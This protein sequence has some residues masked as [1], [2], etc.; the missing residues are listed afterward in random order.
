MKN[1]RRRKNFVAFFVEKISLP[2]IIKKISREKVFAMWLREIKQRGQF[3]ALYAILV[4]VLFGFVGAGIDLGWYYFNVSRLQNAADAAALAGAR[5]IIDSDEKFKTYDNK[6]VRLVANILDDEPYKLETAGD[7][8]AAAYVLKNISSNTDTAP[9]KN[10]Y[11]YTLIDDWGIGGSSE[12]KMT[13]SLYPGG[14]GNFYYVVHLAENVKHLFLP[15]WFDDMRAP[16]VAVAILTK[17]ETVTVI[18]DTN[19][20]KFGN[21]DTTDSINIISPHAMKDGEVSSPLSPDK[22]TPTYAKN[23]KELKGWSTKSNH[24]EGDIIEIFKD[25]AQLTKTELTKLFGTGNTVTLYAVWENV[26]PHNNRTLWEQMHYLIAKNVYDPDWDVS[27]KKYG[28]S[29]LNHNSF[30]T[31]DKTYLSSYHYYTEYINL[32]AK[33]ANGTNLS[34]VN[35]Y[36]IDFRRNDWLSVN[37]KWYYSDRNSRTHSLFN[38]NTTYAV[39]SG[40]HDDPMYLRIE[41]EPDVD[42]YSSSY[43][44][45]PVRQ[46]IIN[47]NVDNT[48]DNLRP[49][50][51]YYDGPDKIKSE[52]AP[53]QPVILNLNANFK[54]V[55][56]MPDVPVVINGNG[57]TFEGFIVASEF[58]CLDTSQGSQVK[59]SSNG[60]KITNAS[61]NKIRVNTSN[62]DVYSVSATGKNALDTYNK[63]ATKSSNGFNLSSE[64][65]FRSFTAET[66]VKFNYVFYDSNLTMD[67]SPFYLN[68]GDLIP[69]YKL[70]DG[71]Q[72]R[73]TKWDEVNLYDNPA[74]VSGRK[75]IQKKITGNANIR[76]VRLTNGEPSPL[77]D[78]AGNPVYFCEDYVNLTGTYTVFT[79]DRVADGTRDPKEFLLTKTDELNVP[80][81]DDWK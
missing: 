43:Y 78:E 66:G 77:Y 75:L 16:V 13:P 45:T 61:D 50:F 18:F 49:L 8:V 30:D 51:F 31:I 26:K 56:F 11:D 59:Y 17:K 9:V 72:V 60:Q 15:G 27:T 28:F 55:L 12:I 80:N 32:A 21:D 36:F 19:G 29:K 3:M 63:Y 5:K 24:S 65:K 52:N 76:T 57:H 69:M 10:T 67:S 34:T 53:P 70:V 64:S 68:T 25:G 35:Q 20:G 37:R 73:L 48:A 41:A 1:F 71:K 4:P 44:H 6:A 46:F 7:E 38:V 47:I 14:G 39:R 33:D 74:T 2:V 58:R 79:L 40:K 22:G 81:T 42:H 62:G 54:G 23:Q